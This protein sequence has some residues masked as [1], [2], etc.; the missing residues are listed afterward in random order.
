MT[1]LIERQ[2]KP[3]SSCEGCIWVCRFQVCK[4]SI[5]FQKAEALRAI[6]ATNG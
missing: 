2:A 6:E 4:K 1:P 5:A 3:K